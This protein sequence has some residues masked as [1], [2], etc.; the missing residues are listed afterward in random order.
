VSFRL[1][2]IQ[3]LK[4][5]F[6]IPVTLAGFHPLIF[7]VVNQVAVLFQF[8]EHTEYIKKCPRWMEYIFAT[9]SNHR[10]HHGTQEKYLDRN[11][12]ATFIIWDRMFGTYYPEEE[13]PVYGLTTP[14][15]SGNPFFLVFQE[16]V[17]IIRDV[18]NAKSWKERFW[19]IFG[20][21]IK[22]AKAKREAL[23]KSPQEVPT[24]IYIRPLVEKMN[25]T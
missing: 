6:L 3:E 22:I 15:H 9:P 10:V 14:V 7:F 23:S 25:S 18:K 24:A 19:F 4:I 20:S 8:W 13:R 2:W 21:P 17:D 11:F 1:S 5:I 16:A 12:G